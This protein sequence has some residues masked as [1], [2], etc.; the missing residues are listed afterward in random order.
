MYESR[1]I[2]TRTERWYH[3]AMTGIMLGRPKDMCG[4]TER[5]VKVYDFLDGLGIGYERIDHE[6]VETMEACREI[7]RLL[8]PAAVCKNLFL[9][10]SKGDE[11]FLLM[12][13]GDKRFVGREVARQIGST[14]LSFGSAQKMEEL[15]STHPGSASVMGLMYD[16]SLRV[17]FLV[18]GDILSDEYLGCHPCVNTSSLRL[19]TSDVFNVFLP[20]TGHEYTIVK[21]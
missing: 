7:D 15:L 14:R 6:A 21:V 19:R 11:Y 12:L 4:R 3:I 13:R 18:D 20:A 10:N 17:K 16:K 9:T 1:L 8:A 5:E 2:D